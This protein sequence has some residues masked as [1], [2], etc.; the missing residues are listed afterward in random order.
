MND[1]LWLVNHPLWGNVTGIPTSRNPDTPEG[2]ESRLSGGIHRIPAKLPHS[3]EP[4]LRKLRRTRTD[5]S[6]A[7]ALK[8]LWGL[9]TSWEVLQPLEPRITLYSTTMNLGALSG[10]KPDYLHTFCQ[11]EHH[12]FYSR[13][14][15]VLSLKIGHVGPTCQASQPCNLVGRPSFL[16]A[17][18]LGIGFL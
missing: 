13:S 10:A 2:L 14:K 3:T 15:A 8:L 5:S 6:R 9:S 11:G 17:P 7:S 12:D 16:P 18:P 1:L 4:R